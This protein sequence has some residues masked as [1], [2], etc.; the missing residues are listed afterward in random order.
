MAHGERRQCQSSERDGGSVRVR[1]A[2]RAE[3][4]VRAPTSIG[5]KLCRPNRVA[6]A[7]T[8]KPKTTMPR[9]RISTVDPVGGATGH[10]TIRPEAEM[11]PMVIS[12]HRS[13]S[14]MCALTNADFRGARDRDLAITL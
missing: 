3:V 9:R 13:P 5:S 4:D 11:L 14:R 12:I 10:F 1:L 6:V 8:T 7:Q 2:S